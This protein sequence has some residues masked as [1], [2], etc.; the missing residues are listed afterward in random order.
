MST[1]KQNKGYFHG[2]RNPTIHTDGSVAFRFVA[3]ATTLGELVK[4]SKWAKKVV[5]LMLSERSNAITVK[6]RRH[7]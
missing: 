2:I 5:G 1:G 4:A 7:I 6:D 3:G